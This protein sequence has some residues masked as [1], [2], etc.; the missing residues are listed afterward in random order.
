MKVKALDKGTIRLSKPNGEMLSAKVA[1]IVAAM[2]A[3]S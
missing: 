3:S 2:V 1:M